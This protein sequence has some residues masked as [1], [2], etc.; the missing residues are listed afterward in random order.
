MN[1]I[2]F[3]TSISIFLLSAG[4]GESDGESSPPN[5]NRGIDDLARTVV[6][7]LAQDQAE[8]MLWAG[9]GTFISAEGLILTNAHVA[10]DMFDE[11][12]NTEFPDL[13]VATTEQTDEPPEAAYIAEVSGIDYALDLA[14]IAIVSDL[15]GEPVDVD[16]PFVSVADSEGVEIGDGINIL[17]YPG[18]GGET[19]TFTDGVVSGFTSERSIGSRAWIKTDATVAHGNSGGLAASN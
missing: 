15:S 19:I 18:I 3:V 9:S 6:Q 10:G 1:R 2:L 16:F 12:P 17:G 14:V 11:L 4:C 7:I 8:E 13:V 5:A